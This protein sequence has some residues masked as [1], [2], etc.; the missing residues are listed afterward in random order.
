MK[1]S[2][3]N[4]SQITGGEFCG[5][6][7]ESPFNSGTHPMGS[8]ERLSIMNSI[9]PDIVG[10]NVLDLFAGTGA[11]G[12]EALS[13][14]SSHVTFV[15]KSHKT[16]EIIKKN[17]K[18]LGIDDRATV[19]EKDVNLVSFDGPYDIVFIDPPY[20]KMNDFDIESIIEKCQD[21]N[22]I[23]LSHKKGTDFDFQD[24][25]KRTKNFAGASISIFTK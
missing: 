24:Y 1:A 4:L 6:K 9:G 7:I 19:I 11:L 14:G 3:V 10:K 13:R 20:D 15:E 16:A 25:S 12:I 8:R 18:N 22:T 17:L 2:S 23:V 21:V 5:R